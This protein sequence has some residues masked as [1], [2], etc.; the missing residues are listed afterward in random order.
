M[1]ISIDSNHAEISLDL[2]YTNSEDNCSIK[3][4]YGN[5]RQSDDDYDIVMDDD[6]LEIE[7]SD[8]EVGFINDDMFNSDN[9]KSTSG[10]TEHQRAMIMSRQERSVAILSIA[11]T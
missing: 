3:S 7:S 2:E 6:D 5:V 10:N 11:N 8:G 1:Y 9:L 4:D